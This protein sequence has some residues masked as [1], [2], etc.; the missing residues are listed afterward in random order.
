MNRQD[1][2]DLPRMKMGRVTL[3]D[4]GAHRGP[5]WPLPPLSRPRRV[6]P[7]V[8]TMHV[9]TGRAAPRGGNV[10]T[11]QL[12]TSAVV[13]VVILGLRLVGAP[14]ARH[15]LEG[16][17]YALNT[18]TRVE[19]LGDFGD[20]KFL[21]DIREKSLAVF[22][23]AVKE[24]AAF[25]WPVETP[26][27][28]ETAGDGLSLLITGEGTVT[29]AMDGQVFYVGED[30]VLGPY[31]RVRHA[32]GW[33]TLYSPVTASVR[34]GDD[35][36]AGQPLGTFSGTLRFEI[37]SNGQTVNAAKLLPPQP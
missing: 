21:S 12:S 33:D 8:A 5:E 18:T 20:L 28:V 22:A 24:D 34:V 11:W 29:A 37:W 4:R 26:G 9:R 23:P 19:D 3:V 14:W 7:G 27:Q 6:R 25:S 32:G 15:T 1:P 30:R 36:L 13:V 31:V 35:V 16:L 17:D 2:K 10:F